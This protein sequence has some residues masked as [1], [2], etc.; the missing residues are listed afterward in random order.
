MFRTEPAMTLARP[1]E[2]VLPVA[3]GTDSIVERPNGLGPHD[4]MERE[5]G[6]PR[7]LRRATTRFT[8]DGR[9]RKPGRIEW[10]K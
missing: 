3:L 2:S 9:T 8:Y 1:F 10:W 5:L 4:A 7:R 6:E